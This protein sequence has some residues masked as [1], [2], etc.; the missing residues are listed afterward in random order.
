MGGG[1]FGNRI[2]WIKDAIRRALDCYRDSPLDVVLV[3][4]GTRVG[5]EW[6]TIANRGGTL[7]AEQTVRPLIETLAISQEHKKMVSVLNM[8]AV[9]AA[10]RGGA[11][12]SR[13]CGGVQGEK[14]LTSQSEESTEDQ[15]R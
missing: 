11:S 13:G 9:S 5:D 14:D 10:S 3:H 2:G 1:A 15:R 8:A 6:G 12:S 4:Y 7:E